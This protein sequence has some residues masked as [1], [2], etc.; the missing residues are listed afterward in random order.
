MSYGSASSVAVASPA[1]KRASS[2]RRVGSAN[3][4]GVPPIRVDLKSE[5][6]TETLLR[7]DAG[8]LNHLAP[9]A[10]LDLYEVLKLLRRT[11]ERLEAYAA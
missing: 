9:L 8:V 3:A 6:N 2:P 11:G 4:N 10:K 1:A 5:R 7:L